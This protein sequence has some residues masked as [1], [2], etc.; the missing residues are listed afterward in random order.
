MLSTVN[1]NG[2]TDP[3]TLI[4]LYNEAIIQISLAKN[5]TINA[6]AS[7]TVDNIVQGIQTAQ[8][9]TITGINDMLNQ[10][11]TSIQATGQSLIYS[12]LGAKQQMHE[13]LENFNSQEVLHDQTINVA[14]TLNATLAGTEN[15]AAEFGVFDAVDNIIHGFG[16]IPNKINGF[17]QKWW[18]SFFSQAEIDALE[19]EIETEMEEMETEKETEETEELERPKRH[20]E[21]AENMTLEQL[22]GVLKRELKFWDALNVA[23]GRQMRKL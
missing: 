9:Q 3:G 13:F 5:I 19:T 14:L 10:T 11:M 4:Q 12:L 21:V 23:L 7:L 1:V 15:L 17:I 8:N 6:I 18:T 2:T 22:D 20:L 16:Q